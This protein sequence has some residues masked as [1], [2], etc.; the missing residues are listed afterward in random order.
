LPGLRFFVSQS[1]RLEA[2]KKALVWTAFLAAIF[3]LAAACELNAGGVESEQGG[4]WYGVHSAQPG[5][6]AAKN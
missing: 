1:A 6:R 2:R 5:R 3:G 4:N